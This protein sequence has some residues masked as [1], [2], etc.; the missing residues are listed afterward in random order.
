MSQFRKLTDAELD[1]V[2]EVIERR[3]LNYTGMLLDTAREMYGEAVHRPCNGF[4][5]PADAVAK[6]PEDAA[7]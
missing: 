1:A 4:Y 2:W 7:V 6:V 3:K 5:V